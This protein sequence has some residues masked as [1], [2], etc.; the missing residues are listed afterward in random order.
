M[1][2]N[3][4]ISKTNPNYDM[5]TYNDILNCKNLTDVQI[6]NEY[7]KL[8]NLNYEENSRSFCGNKIIYN[9]VFENM[10]NTRRNVKNYL[11]LKEIFENQELKEKWINQTIKM[12]RRKKLDYIEPVDIYECY[13]RCKGSVNTFKAGSV[14]YLINKFNASKML[15]FTAGWGGRLLGARSMN[16]DY[17]GIDTNTNLKPSYD[18]MIN[19]FGG[20]MIWDSCLNVDF[21]KL[22]YDFV[23]TSP[24]YINLEQYE[25]MEQFENNESF[26]INFLIPMI[27]KSLKY[28][29]NNGSVCINISNYMY[30]DYIK[31]GGKPCI[32]KIDLLQ[33][34]GGKPN[35]EIIYVFKN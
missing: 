4:Q 21:S 11:I 26:Y 29:K 8:Q 30:D 17:I 18:K 34:L 27:E 16:I 15:D 3:D 19:K 32:E 22:D 2:S 1:T 14:K 12:N 13:R 23:L 9:Y 24:P 5:I 10:L 31:F 6:S 28:I 33:Q 25:N 20:K 35:K 7:N